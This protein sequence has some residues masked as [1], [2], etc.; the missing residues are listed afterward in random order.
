MTSRQMSYGDYLKIDGLLGQQSPKSVELGAPAHDEMLFIIVH[1]A[2]ELWF[3]QILHELSSVM[4]MFSESTVDEKNMG[5]C[6][7]RLERVTD[8]QKLL[9]DHIR[10]LETMTPLDFLEFRDL[11]SPAS[12]FQSVQFRKIELMLGLPGG[13]RFGCPTSPFVTALSA[14]EVRDVRESAKEPSLFD[15]V[16]RWLERT[17]FL[18]VEGYSF[19]KSYREAVK[20]RLEADVQAIKTHPTLP[21][22]NKL[23]QLQEIQ[24]T[25][26]SFEAL[27]NEDVH[28]KLVKEGHRRLSLRATHAALFINL[29]RDQPILH[30]PFRLLTLL[31]DIDELLQTWRSQHAVM[32]HRM[33]GV[34]V[35]TGGSMGYP[36]LKSTVE[37]FKIFNDFFNL[38]TFLIP[39]SALPEL[40]FE[41]KQR[42][43]FAFHPNSQNAHSA[44]SW[45]Q[46]SP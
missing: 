12:G 46:A 35:G 15:L 11:L 23:R 7:A 19:W 28:S 21:E 43:A 18:D 39:R 31:V 34:K 1:Q 24:N 45:N 27:F 40:P 14:S 37:R 16:E 44:E 9:V 36:Y 41:L 25:E 2:H 29:Y 13:E 17:P 8:I 10:V 26:L 42:L 6:V 4:R 30:M 5:V 33:I 38:S 3:K 22:E 20:G 32:V